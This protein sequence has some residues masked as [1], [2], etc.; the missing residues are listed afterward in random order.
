[1]RLPPL[2]AADSLYRSSGH[3][4][5]VRTGEAGAATVV[6]AIPFCGNCDDI[7]DRCAENGG[8]PRAVCRA[9]AVGNCFSGVENPL[10][11]LFP[12]RQRFPWIW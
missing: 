5:P 2:T 6:A 10:E 7:L 3:Y 12:P 9:C 8:R 1:M 4:R 11:P